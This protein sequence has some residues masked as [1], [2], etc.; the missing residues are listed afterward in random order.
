[1]RGNLD[2]RNI[3]LVFTG[4]EFRDGLPHISHVLEKKDVGASFFVTGKFLEDKK[5]VNLLKKLAKKGHYIGPHSDKHLLYS[6]WENRDSLLLTKMEFV[7]DL[8]ANVQCLEKIGIER[9][10]IFIAP[11][12]WYNKKIVEWS[13]EMGFQVYNFTPGLRTPA[14]Y[15]YPEMG[16]RYMSSFRILNQLHEFEKANGLNGYIIL[17]HLG[18][19]SRRTDKLYLKLEQIIDELRSK[20]Y[21]FVSL[22]NL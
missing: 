21:N 16:A 13:T 11:Y 5:S 19:D 17:I 4:D 9:G 7:N 10:N 1:M 3:S 15:T 6:P 20:K 18:T 22:E 2:N 12:E 8:E 14:D